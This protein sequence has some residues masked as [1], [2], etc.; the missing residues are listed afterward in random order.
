MNFPFLLVLQWP[1]IVSKSYSGFIYREMAGNCSCRPER[2]AYITSCNSTCNTM[3]FPCF[4]G[5]LHTITSG[6]SHGPHG[7]RQG[8]Q[9]C[10]KHDEK[11]PRTIRDH[12][13]LQN[14]VYWS[15]ELLVWRR[16]A[17]LG[18]WVGYPQHWNS[19]Q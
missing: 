17:S 1:Y 3:T 10:T 6:S 8:L 13:L 18:I 16:S 7:V 9:Y 5:T 14:A 4:S 2:T 19:P 12:L 15:D 11:C